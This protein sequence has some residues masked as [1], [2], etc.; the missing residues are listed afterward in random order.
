MKHKENQLNNRRQRNREV[1]FHL[2]AKTNPEFH[3]L[4][5]MKR[6]QKIKIDKSHHLKV[7]VRD[8]Y[9]K[10]NEFM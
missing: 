1:Y 8:F 6:I 4:K 10:E 5:T 3:K 9:E 7:K 2:R